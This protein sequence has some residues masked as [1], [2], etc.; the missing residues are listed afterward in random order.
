MPT[1]RRLAL[2]VGV[3]S[4]VDVGRID[5]G[6]NARAGAVGRREPRLALAEWERDHVGVER[7][8]T[9]NRRAPQAS[10]R[11]TIATRVIGG[12]RRRALI[13][14]RRDGGGGGGDAPVA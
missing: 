7:R 13:G 10:G 9:A 2:I 12:T 5:A 8:A 6:A 11:H 1:L 14:E 4:L 3:C